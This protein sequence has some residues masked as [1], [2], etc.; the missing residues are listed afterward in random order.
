MKK[1]NDQESVAAPP[2]SIRP[3]SSRSA[4]SGRV[5]E[6]AAIQRPIDVKEL[7]RK[8]LTRCENTNYKFL[9]YH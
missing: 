7:R 2:A 9:F 4:P 3:S 1:Q 6:Q 8:G 5:G